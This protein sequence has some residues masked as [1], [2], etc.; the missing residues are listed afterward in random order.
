MRIV[1]THST[2]MII[3]L[4]VMQAAAKNT[5][6]VQGSMDNLVDKF[7]DKLVS[8]AHKASSLHGVDL[9]GFFHLTNRS[10]MG[11]PDF[12]STT[13]GKHENLPSAR[14]SRSPRLPASRPGFLTAPVPAPHVWRPHIYAPASHRSFGVQTRALGFQTGVQRIPEGFHVVSIFPD[15]EDELLAAWKQP[16]RSKKE[17][18]RSHQFRASTRDGDDDEYYYSN[19]IPPSRHFLVFKGGSPTLVSEGPWQLKKRRPS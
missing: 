8:R 17:S 2:T 3:L 14:A 13:L 9:A 18:T 16:R 12:D 5:R 7:V 6:D 1:I 4:A 10:M 19:Y 15:E 11:G